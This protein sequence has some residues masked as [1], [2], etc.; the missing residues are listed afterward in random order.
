MKFDFRPIAVFCISGISAHSQSPAQKE[1]S[2]P[3]T[4]VVSY[5]RISESTIKGKTF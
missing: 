3:N 5:L 1:V 2:N 4:I